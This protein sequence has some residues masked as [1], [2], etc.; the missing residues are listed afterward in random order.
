MTNSHSFS[1]W[2]LLK[3]TSHSKDV[4]SWMRA[5]SDGTHVNAIVPPSGVVKNEWMYQSAGILDKSSDRVRIHLRVG[6]S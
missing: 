5:R 4:T 1:V 3:V 6:T 2:T